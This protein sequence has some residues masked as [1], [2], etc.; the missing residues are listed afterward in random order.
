MEGIWL[1]GKRA[2]RI[3][4]LLAAATAAA[5]TIV[6]LAQPAPAS[7]AAG[8]DVQARTLFLTEQVR[9]GAVRGAL[10]GPVQ[11]QHMVAQPGEE[12]A[13]IIAFR[14]PRD[15][16]V[17]A[18]LDASSSP[19]ARQW[20][21]MLRMEWV[22]VTRPSTAMGSRPG[23]Y[24]DPLPPQVAGQGN[25]GRLLARGGQWNAFVVLVSVPAAQPAGTETGTVLVRDAA[26]NVLVR[27]RFTMTTV[28]TRRADGAADPAIAP[29]DARNFKMLFGFNPNWYR[30]LAPAKTAQEQYEQTYR[31]LWMLARHRAAPNQWQKAYPTGN[32]TYDCSASDGYLKVFAEMP[33]WADGRAGALPVAL[34]PNHAVARCTTDGFTI[35][36]EKGKASK[37]DHKVGDPVRSAWFIYR[38]ADHW[39]KA[40]IQDHRT[41]FLNPFDEP[42]PEQN[43]TEVP[44]VNKMV[45]DYAPGVKVLGTTWPM[46]RAEQRV[47]RQ[48][49]GRQVCA[50]RRGQQASNGHLRDGQG[51][52]DLDGW[53]APYFRMFGFGVTKTQR[54]LGI[55]RSR[56]VIDRLRQIQRNGGEAWTY[57]LPLGTRRVPQLAID[58]PS[59]DARFL[60]W[61]LGREG[62]QGWFSAVTNRWVDPYQTTTPR[63][64]WDAPLSWVGTEAL[65]REN[66]GPHGVVSNGW[67]SLYYPGYR[68]K[69]GLIDPLAQPVS[70]LR[71]QRMRDGVEDVNMMRQYR[72]RFGQKALDDA[73]LGVLGS[74]QAGTDLPGNET[75]PRYRQPGL[76]LRMEIIRRQMLARL[77]Q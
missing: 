8:G 38:I 49:R 52:D 54:E 31:T 67:G 9:P 6:L 65:D 11:P 42:S 34:M 37:F 72:D 22:N 75:F 4:R 30:A 68:P 69:L 23:R 18:V 73:L 55:D 76:S 47:C 2:Q 70:S 10:R 25:A 28:V 21:Q 43:L 41:Y 35:R 62:T 33:W 60:Y 27:S 61:P 5:M 39:R 36:D 57:D 13:Y 12:E 46:E 17:D 40:G 71:L 7:A 56:E 15:V 74:L 50:M 58:G 16:Y 20:T 1:R 14:P 53:V 44:K 45:H 32:G 63:N 19:F 66:T 51:G 77:A 3:A 24:A 59:T 29:H 48:L 26:G 64:P